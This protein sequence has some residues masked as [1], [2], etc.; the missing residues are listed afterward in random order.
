MT[1]R[2]FSY[3]AVDRSG[4]TRRGVVTAAGEQ[5]AYRQLTADG[6][7]PLS[8]RERRVKGAS[9][10]QGWRASLEQIADLTRELAVLVEARIPIGRGLLSIAEHEKRAEMRD[11]V[12][13]IATFIE[14][15]G[16]F[17]AAIE[18]HRDSFGEVYVETI[19][20][21][22]RTGNLPVMM[23]HLAE[24]MDRTIETRQQLRRAMTYPLI[25]LAAVG[26]A[27]GVIVIFVVPRFGAT[28][29]ANGV[30]MPI[31]TEAVKTLG[32]SIKRHWYIYSASIGALLAGGWAA[33]RMPAGRRA[34]ETGMERLPY[35]GRIIAAV[36]ASRFAHV[37]GIG[38]SSGLDLVESL[39]MSGRATGRAVFAEECDRMAERLRRG[40][41]LSEVLRSGRSLP[42][43]ARRMIAAGKDAQEVSKSCGVVARHYDRE[44]SH[45]TK[46]ISTVI[47]PVMTIA[48]AAIVL[49]VALSVFLPMWQMVKLNR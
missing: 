30:D 13:D 19:R 45:L 12:R 36:T 6:L 35:I 43:F 23:S 31:V 22:E 42:S 37:L 10:Q 34:I 27:L 5:E 38:L 39:E 29:E 2:Q 44:S 26:L 40:D 14:S 47:E 32:E 49:L 41:Q 1:N 16:S 9:R 48:L 8:V 21:A 46:N 24:L 28:F 20:A 18:R 25:V 3:E 7:T 11:M 17:T 15:G 4:A 33:W